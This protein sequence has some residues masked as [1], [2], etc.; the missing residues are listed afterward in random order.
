MEGEHLQAAAQGG[1]TEDVAM[2][3]EEL[4]SVEV[5]RT[6][7]WGVNTDAHPRQIVQTGRV[8]N[9]A[10]K[11]AP[12]KPPP[13][14]VANDLSKVV[15]RLR[16]SVPLLKYAKVDKSLRALVLSTLLKNCWDEGESVVVPDG[17]MV[18]AL[19]PKDFEKYRGVL[20]GVTPEN[21]DEVEAALR[22]LG[23]HE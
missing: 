10:K 18:Q 7:E 8:L 20:G 22:Q 19:G 3:P 13:K 5:R 1:E 2:Q 21:E 14:A 23:V 11:P 4:T 17:L 9:K 16:L 6:R 12:P 15:T